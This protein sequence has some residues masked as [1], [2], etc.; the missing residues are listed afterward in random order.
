[1]SFT[2]T[3]EGWWLEDNHILHAQCQNADGEKVE[4]TIDLDTFVGNSDGWFIWDGEN[5]SLSATDVRLDG[6]YLSA[7]LA[8][9]E[10]GSRERQGLELNDR[11]GNDNGQLV[12]TSLDEE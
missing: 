12:Y 10:G 5:F 8:T 11:I 2:E 9:V 1:M 6:S 7:E 4:S 3:S